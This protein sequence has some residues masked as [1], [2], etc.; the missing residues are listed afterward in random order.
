LSPKAYATTNATP[1]DDRWWSKCAHSITPAV[2]RPR[3]LMP[4]LQQSRNRPSLTKEPRHTGG[5]S[6]STKTQQSQ[7]APW[8]SAQPTLQAILRQMGTGLN[9]TGRT[10]AE[11]GAIDRL[12]QNPTKGN[13]YAGQIGGYAQSLL[14]GGAN[15]QAGNMQSNLEAFTNRLWLQK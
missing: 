13:P 12:S 15:A 4:V 7:T 8:T 3:W 9:N 2:A 11:T 1:T 14:G 5:E 6:S 10:G